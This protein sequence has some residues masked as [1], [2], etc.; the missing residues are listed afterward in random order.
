MGE[1][2][3]ILRAA[4]IGRLSQKEPSAIWPALGDSGV[5]PL[6]VPVDLGGLGLGVADAEPVLDALGECCAASSFLETSIIAA[7]LLGLS[8]TDA[9]DEI[10]RRIATDH[11]RVAVA[12]LDARLRGNVRAHCSD[13]HWMIDGSAPIVLDADVSD[14]ILVVAQYDG[15]PAIFL[16]PEKSQFERRGFPTIDGRNAADLS[17]HQTPVI[18]IAT[19]AT[20]I[21]EIVS[22]EAV[23]CLAI[24]ASS[25]MCRLVHDTVVYAKQ[26]EQFGQ[27]IGRF[28]VIQH[29]LVDM[30]IQARRSGAIARKAMAALAGPQIERERAVSAAKVTVAQAG[31]FIGQ[32]AVQLHG[33][34]GMTIELPIGRCFKRLTVI[35]SELGDADQHLERFSATMSA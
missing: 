25:L 10:L 4:I 35:E 23:A 13:G 3:A 1:D 31:R 28:Q 16:V 12:G 30:N 33:G 14:A 21:L 15:K 18:P 7:R 32:Q 19:D 24:E 27:S 22:D 2:H 26:R 29:R 34:M 20:G 9:G 17:F 6:C 5:V 8:R 11:W